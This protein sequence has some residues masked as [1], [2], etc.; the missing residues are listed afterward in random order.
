MWQ[1]V[2]SQIPGIDFQETFSP[3]ARIASVRTLIPCA[4]QNDQI[5]HQMD[6]K[7]AYLNAPIDCELYVEQT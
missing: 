3:K 7:T 2:F 5:I 1:R 4:I 6:V